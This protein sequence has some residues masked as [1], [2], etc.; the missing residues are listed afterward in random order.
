[1]DNNFKE[2][3]R[4]RI[5]RLA[6][7]GLF[8][9][10]ICVACIA[11]WPLYK[12]LRHQYTN[13]LI[14]AV[15][16]R[17]MVAEEFVS[18]IKA[19][20]RQITSRTKAR[21]ALEKYNRREI[22]LAGFQK[23]IRPI[24]QDALN[25]SESAVGITR[26]DHK[27]TPVV[28]VG[29][30]LPPTFLQQTDLSKYKA[31]FAHGLF[32]IA[33]KKLIVVSA[34]IMN[35]R[36]VQVGTDVVLFKPAELIAL[37]KDYTGFG[38]SGESLLLAKNADGNGKPLFAGRFKTLPDFSHI[39]SKINDAVNSDTIHLYETESDYI[40]YAQLQG[41]DFVMVVRMAKDE[42]HEPINKQISKVILLISVLIIPLG[43]AGLVI[44][45][46]PCETAPSY[47]LTPSK[48]H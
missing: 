40:S 2:F 32:T 11:I 10:C 33:E 21:Q 4:T 28:Q 16:I 6:G 39:L 38:K 41:I 18:K 36:N 15:K 13:S 45:M 31:P 30:A 20:A 46:R 29:L 37:V 43:L 17:G 5:I 8:L 48:M 35:R 27:R 9:A 22:D 47:I 25:L 14:Y 42:L 23:Y 7:V 26:L 34:P 24:L 3:F 12:E 19:T 1:M 44:L